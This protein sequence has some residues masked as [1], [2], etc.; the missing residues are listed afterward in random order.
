MSEKTEKMIIVTICREMPPKVLAW[1]P[2]KVVE[3][4]YHEVD[5]RLRLDESQSAVSPIL[6]SCE[7]NLRETIKHHK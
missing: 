5:S 1:R 6:I 2:G 7:G 4:T 3:I